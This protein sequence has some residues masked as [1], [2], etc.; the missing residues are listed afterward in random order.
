MKKEYPYCFKWESIDPE[1]NEDEV[2]DCDIFIN[3]IKMD[4]SYFYKF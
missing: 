1:G 3:D 4:F 2:K